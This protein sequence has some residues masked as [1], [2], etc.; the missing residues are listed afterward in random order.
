[1]VSPP[2]I[3]PFQL[4]F[5]FSLSNQHSACSGM[6]LQ[7]Y[8]PVR[9]CR[10]LFYLW[11]NRFVDSV[12]P[13]WTKAKWLGLRSFSTLDDA[14]VYWSTNEIE[15]CWASCEVRHFR[16]NYLCACKLHA[17]HTTHNLKKHTSLVNKN[18]S[19]FFLFYCAL[20]NH[21]HY[22]GLRSSS[23]RRVQKSCLIS[24]SFEQNPKLPTM[25]LPVFFAYFGEALPFSSV[26]PDVWM[27]V[28]RHFKMCSGSGQRS[29]QN[30]QKTSIELLL[31]Q[32]FVCSGCCWE[33]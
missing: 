2:E 31:N 11:H 23:Y 27:L 4:V 28:D 20:L 33:F 18:Q 15:R 26:D 19:R 22:F 3:P 24:I 8:W 13:L 9:S 5:V 1:M 14:R 12:S 32:S 25:Q 6:F 16:S 10:W 21:L 29:G 7:L 17:F 30:T